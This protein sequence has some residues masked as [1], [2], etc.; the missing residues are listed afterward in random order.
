[1][2]FDVVTWLGDYVIREKLAA[3]N[4][5]STPNQPKRET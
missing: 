5:A 1:M 2:R 3:P 4:L